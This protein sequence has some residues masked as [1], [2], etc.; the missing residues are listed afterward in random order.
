MAESD[1]ITC[2][3]AEQLLEAAKFSQTRA[4]GREAIM[5][6]SF[7]VTPSFTDSVSLEYPNEVRP[8]SIRD[9]KVVA[10]ELRHAATCSKDGGRSCVTARQVFAAQTTSSVVFS[11]LPFR[12]SHSL[13]GNVPVIDH[14]YVR[15]W[16]ELAWCKF[17]PSVTT[18]SLS[19]LVTSR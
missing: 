3:T 14:L 7:L 4:R 11:K 19:S 5:P 17:S 8:L 12:T 1:R 6:D 15:A 18:G 10:N 16:E 9:S 2:L 13:P